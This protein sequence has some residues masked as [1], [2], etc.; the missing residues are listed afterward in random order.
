MRYFA[1]HYAQALY[2]ALHNKK[3]TEQKTL[4]KNFFLLLR[5]RR[6]WSR[7][8]EIV[9]AYEKYYLKQ[10][11]MHKVHVESAYACSDII[12]TRITNAVG[13]ALLWEEVVRP[14]L[15]GG[16]TILVDSEILVDAS[17]KRLLEKMFPPLQ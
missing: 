5:A 17:V 2:E 10:K 7:I 11:N 16:I 14:E 3:E 12:R 13:E 6:E 9:C 8:Q 4:L 15:L 1:I